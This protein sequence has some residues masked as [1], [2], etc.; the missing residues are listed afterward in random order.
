MTNYPSIAAKT[1]SQSTHGLRKTEAEVIAQQARLASKAK[2]LD[3]LKIWAVATP[4][5]VEIIDLDTDSHRIRQGLAPVFKSGLYTF[6]EADSFSFYINQHK[7]PGRTTL[8]AD[9]STDTLLAVFDDHEA[10][11]DDISTAGWRSF[12]ARLLLKRTPA[13]IDWMTL[14]GQRKS[15][16]EFADFLEDHAS[17][18]R[19]P[20]AAELLEIATTLQAT[21][22]AAM[23][24]ALRLDSGQVQFRYE[25]TVE[26][27]AGHT[28]TLQIPSRIALGI[29]PYEGVAPFRID[30]RLRYRLSAGAVT[31]TLLLDRPAEVERFCFDQLLK[32]IG[33]A[34]GLLPLHGIPPTL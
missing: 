6:S 9:L 8:Y 24:S 12:R 34:T 10:G 5:G 2:E 1:D 23:K 26:A 4:T 30:A 13:W 31:F 20:A 15:Q 14:S 33:E 19:E 21:T 25:E 18:I 17:D 28:G 32:D 16:A 7:Q 29:A 27:K 3:P 11:S 22:G